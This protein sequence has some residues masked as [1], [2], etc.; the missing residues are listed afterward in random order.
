M[1]RVSGRGEVPRGE[2]ENEENEENEE[3]GDDMKI[4]TKVKAGD[5]YGITIS[6]IYVGK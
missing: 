4:K 6:V 5:E 1:G 2:Q 3:D